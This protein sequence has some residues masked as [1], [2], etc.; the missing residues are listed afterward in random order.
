[1]RL[2]ANTT[3]RRHLD[4]VLREFVEHYNRARPHR[5]LGLQAPEQRPSARVRNEIP[6][7]RRKDR[8]GGL[9]HEYEVAA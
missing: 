8:L 7:V 6:P 9:I 1:M 3:S 4:Q 5:S 2:E